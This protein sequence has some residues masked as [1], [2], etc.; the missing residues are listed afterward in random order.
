MSPFDFVAA[1]AIGA[2][3][4]HV[5][6][7]GT[8]ATWQGPQ[9]SLASRSCIIRSRRCAASRVRAI[10]RTSAS[11]PG[12]EWP[13][14]GP[15]TVPVRTDLQRPVWAVTPQRRAGPEGGAIRDLKSNAGGF[16]SCARRRLAW[17]PTWCGTFLRKRQSIRRCPEQR[18][19]PWRGVKR[20]RCVVT[21][22]WVAEP[23]QD[24]SIAA[25]PRCMRIAKAD[26]MR[27]HSKRGK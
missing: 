19:R 2:I 3:V 6:N 5:P 18:M 22:A 4:G 24:G 16:R 20:S 10:D 27:R 11:S 15:R 8:Q 21:A 25:A 12:R 9:R 13:G 17:R 26:R 1:V 14:A 7:A 23:N